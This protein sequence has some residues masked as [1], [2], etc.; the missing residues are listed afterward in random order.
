MLSSRTTEGF[1][2]SPAA[3]GAAPGRGRGDEVPSRDAVIAPPCLLA[4][5]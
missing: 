4:L 1:R 5:S 3:L 2:G